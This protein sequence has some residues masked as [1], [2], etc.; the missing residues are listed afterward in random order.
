MSK[1]EKEICLY[2]KWWSSKAK[3]DEKYALISDGRCCLRAPQN[4]QKGD[5]QDGFFVRTEWVTTQGGD[6]CGEFK[7]REAQ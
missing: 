7:E 1:D 5:Q 3:P 4:F 2:C 6:F